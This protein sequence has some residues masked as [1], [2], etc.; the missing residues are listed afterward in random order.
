[1]AKG[2]FL[3]TIHAKSLFPTSRQMSKFGVN[4]R[5]GDLVGGVV[6]EVVVVLKV[7]V[8]KSGLWGIVEDF[9]FVKDEGCL[10]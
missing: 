5:L 8:V 10:F 4:F 2:K 7:G 9:L 3:I 1:M 6:L